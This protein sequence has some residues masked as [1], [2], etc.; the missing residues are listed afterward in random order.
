MIRL[1]RQ[2]RCFV[3][4]QMPHG[5]WSF[6]CGQA[7]V[8]NTYCRSI[9]D[10]LL[11]IGFAM[12]CHVI[13]FICCTRTNFHFSEA[14]FCNTDFVIFVRCQIVKI[15]KF[16]KNSHI[17]FLFLCDQVC[18][19]PDGILMAHCILLFHGSFQN[20]SLTPIRLIVLLW[21]GKGYFD[22]YSQATSQ[23][24]IF[25]SKAVR[26]PSGRNVDDALIRL[27]VI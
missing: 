8:G 12:H 24:T 18:G 19:W 1:R 13:S 16:K 6:C 4:F 14:L 3:C 2:S 11:Y 21:D 20:K 22:T 27:Q 5:F 15:N 7:Q 25:R 17:F 10:L 9:Q 23:S 26:L